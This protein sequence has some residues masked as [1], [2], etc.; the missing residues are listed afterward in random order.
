MLMPAINSEGFLLDYQQWNIEV[1]NQ[2]A[3]NEQIK[4]TNEHLAIIAVIREFY[5]E[6]TLHPGMRI[7]I[8]ILQQKIG[9]NDFKIDSIYIHLKFPQGI[10]QLSKIA[11]L[12]KPINCI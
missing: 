2:L 10:K 9:H 11:G 6:Y 5:Q 1:A 8:K 3:Q 12:P 4:L 7:L